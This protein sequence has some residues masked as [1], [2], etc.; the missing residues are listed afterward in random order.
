[1]ALHWC[2]M[3]RDLPPYSTV[4]WHYKQWRA[5]GFFEQLP[6][7]SPDLPWVAF[8]GVEGFVESSNLIFPMICGYSFSNSC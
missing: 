8:S 3:P 7:L 6:E 5:A 4:Y 1:M 2:D